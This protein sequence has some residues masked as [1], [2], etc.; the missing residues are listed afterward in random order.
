MK[1]ASIVYGD[2]HLMEIKAKVK[3]FN[4][5]ESET[6]EITF[7]EDELESLCATMLDRLMRAMIQNTKGS[8]EVRKTHE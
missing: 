1:D 5:Y 4:D 6:V 2:C 7:S 8:I 3:L